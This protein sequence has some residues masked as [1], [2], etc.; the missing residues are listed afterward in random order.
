[1]A[2]IVYQNHEDTTR[3]LLQASLQTRE[4]GYTDE[5]GY[6]ELIILTEGG[7]YRH[8]PS[9]ERLDDAASAASGAALIGFYPTTAGMSATTV[10]A[11]IEELHSAG[12]GGTLTGSGTAGT[13]A[14]WGSTTALSNSILSEASSTLS[15]NLAA[16]VFKNAHATGTFTIETVSGDIVIKSNSLVIGTFKATGLELTGTGVGVKFPTGPGAT[17]LDEYS[18]DSFTIEIAHCTTTVTG[19]ATYVKIGK[20]VTL[21][22]PDLSGIDDGTGL[23]ELL[24][25]PTHIRPGRDGYAGGLIAIVDGF[26]VPAFLEYTVSSTFWFVNYLVFSGI[27]TPGNGIQFPSVA[28]LA[29]GIQGSY[30]EYFV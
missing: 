20:K 7:Q 8:F 12:S 9:L 6:Q 11:A 21:F 13:L 3:A 16:F 28:G 27:P 17:V 10:Q 18:V 24:G 29:K 30:V 25:I 5:A 22:I 14:K 15:V 26:A 19:T 23:F 2:R 4:I 1:M